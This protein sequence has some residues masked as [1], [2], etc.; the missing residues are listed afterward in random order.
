MRVSLFGLFLRCISLMGPWLKRI[1]SLLLVISFTLDSCFMIMLYRP[2]ILYL[3]S[4]PCFLYLLSFDIYPLCSPW[5]ATRHY[6]ILAWGVSLTP[7]D[8]YVQVRELVA[9][10]FPRHWSEWCSG[11]VDLQPTD[12]SHIL[13]GPPVCLSSFFL[14]NSWVPFFYPYLYFSLYAC[15]WAPFCTIHMLYI[16]RTL[17]FA[18][19]SDMIFM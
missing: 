17:A 6:I 11:S 12:Q 4:N 1:Q 14:A 7:L 18:H 9:R 19:T 2:Y 3:C 10:G 15:M 13:P 16:F 8:S 5:L